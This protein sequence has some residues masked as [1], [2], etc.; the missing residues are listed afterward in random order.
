[1]NTPKK[2]NVWRCYPNCDPIPGT[3]KYYWGPSKRWVMKHVASENGITLFPNQM[4]V[5][6]PNGEFYTAIHI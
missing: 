2:Y 4:I 5:K 1:M 6:L 3:D